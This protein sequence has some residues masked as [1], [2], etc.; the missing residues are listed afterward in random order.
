MSHCSKQVLILNVTRMGDLAQTVPLLRRLEEES[1]G[2]AI[3]LV[4][5]T[6]LASMAALLP[7]LRHIHTYDFKNAYMHAP[8]D[9][10]ENAPLS[11]DIAAWA[12][13]LATVG[14]D[15]VINLTF[16]RWSGVL[17]AAIGVLRQ[18]NDSEPYGFSE[19]NL[20]RVGG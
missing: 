7:G 4:I 14:Y 15:R 2:V 9:P 16:I 3:D 18:M 13:S 8:V 1:P 12:Q 5:D 17:A 10:Q 11:P 20:Q 6:R 19:V